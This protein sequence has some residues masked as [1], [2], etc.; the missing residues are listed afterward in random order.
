M[1]FL[2]LAVL[3]CSTALSVAAVVG[4]VLLARNPADEFATVSYYRAEVS[5]ACS[6][7]AERCGGR[8]DWCPLRYANEFFVASH[9]F[10]TA[11]LMGREERRIA[12]GTAQA[13][14]N[15]MAARRLACRP[16]FLLLHLAGAEEEITAEEICAVMP[17]GSYKNAGECLAIT[18]W[19]LE[20]PRTRHRLIEIYREKV[21]K[22]RRERR[23]DKGPLNR[24]LLFSP[25]PHRNCAA[26]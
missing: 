17:P 11:L 13:A 12:N 6:A 14:A 5:F 23:K 9:L 15:E 10:A 4:L 26:A 2:R 25:G 24:A 19:H 8:K 22:F 18:R 3:F 1:R 21:L 20:N 16:P 7:E